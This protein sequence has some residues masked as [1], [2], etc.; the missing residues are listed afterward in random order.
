MTL[1]RNYYYF[2]STN[3]SIRYRWYWRTVTWHG[4]K[5]G[6]VNELEYANSRF[7]FCPSWSYY[8][9]PMSRQ[10]IQLQ[11]IGPT[12]GGEEVRAVRC[13]H[14]HHVSVELLFREPQGKCAPSAAGHGCNTVGIYWTWG[15]AHQSATSGL[16]LSLCACIRAMRIQFNRPEQHDIWDLN[17]ALSTLELTVTVLLSLLVKNNSPPSKLSFK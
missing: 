12:C 5:I 1:S 6:T 15:K 8:P 16:H 2:F 10:Q 11:A 9:R 14:T 7:A 4:C 13:R 3:R 17:R